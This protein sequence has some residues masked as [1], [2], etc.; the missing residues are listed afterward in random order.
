M[1]HLHSLPGPS[2]YL[3]A[4]NMFSCILQQKIVNLQRQN[5]EYE[6]RGSS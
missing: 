2:T 6:E 3:K 4:Q 5:N 1:R